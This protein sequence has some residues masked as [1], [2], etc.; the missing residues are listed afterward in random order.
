MQNRALCNSP[1]LLAAVAP[2]VGLPFRYAALDEV[3]HLSA[4]FLP[5][6]PYT[7]AVTSA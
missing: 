2:F 6:L 7:H 4:A 1:I 3:S 5:G